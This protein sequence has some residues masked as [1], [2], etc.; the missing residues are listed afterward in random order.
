[1]QSELKMD[2]DIIYISTALFMGKGNVAEDDI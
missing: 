1:M 2:K